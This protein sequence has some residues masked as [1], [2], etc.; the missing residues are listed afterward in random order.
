MTPAGPTTEHR[1]R[2]QLYRALGDGTEL[3]PCASGRPATLRGSPH[4]LR[5][6]HCRAE[7]WNCTCATVVVSD[8][9]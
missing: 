6:P 5:C 7:A 4:A 1:I 2:A 3:P 8:V 9:G